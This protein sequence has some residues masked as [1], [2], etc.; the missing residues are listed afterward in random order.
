M[1]AGQCLGTGHCLDYRH[2][3]QMEHGVPIGLRL[4]F[5]FQLRFGFACQFRLGF[6]CQDWKRDELQLN[7]QLALLTEASAGDANASKT[8]AAEEATSNREM[9][10]FI[11]PPKM[12]P[13]AYPA[14]KYTRKPHGGLGELRGESAW[15]KTDAPHEVIG[16]LRPVIG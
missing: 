10:A 15:G 7:L 4:G 2:C 5:A 11:F 12:R 13:A 16:V 6:I 1:S 9:E 3:P 14:S 8:P